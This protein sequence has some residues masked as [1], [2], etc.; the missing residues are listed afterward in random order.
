MDFCS[1]QTSGNRGTQSHGAVSAGLKAS[2][3]AGRIAGG[4]CFWGDSMGAAG[5]G[6]NR[7]GGQPGIQPSGLPFRSNTPETDIAPRDVL[8]CPQCALVQFRTSS[9]LCRRCA[10]PLPPKF[11]ELARAASPQPPLASKTEVLASDSEQPMEEPRNR[12]TRI[13][14]LRIGGRVQAWRKQRGLTQR[15]LATRLGIPRSYLSRIENNRLLPGPRMVPKIAEA[16]AVK[17][18]DLLSAE[19]AQNA[20]PRSGADPTTAALL[21]RLVQLP[22]RAMAAVLNRARRMAARVSPLP[23]SGAPPGSQRRTGRQLTETLRR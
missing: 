16:L 2:R 9:D 13:R 5:N 19:P 3:A 20:R 23:G 15:Q 18:S 21:Q 8:R 1:E 11:P 6:S 4:F 7:W 12:G 14:R 17:I 22:P 10:K